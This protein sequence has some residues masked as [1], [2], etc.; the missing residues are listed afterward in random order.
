MNRKAIVIGA[1]FAGL[2]A[3]T[4]LAHK[5]WDVT[6]LEKNESPG[7]RGRLM[8]QEGYHFDMG[9][10]WYWMP[11]IFER[12]F[13]QFGKSA[14]D[15]YQLVRLNPSYRVFFGKDDLMD[16]PAEMEGLEA[17]FESREPGSRDKLREFL[18]QAAYKYK[19][20]IQE[21]V[22]KPSLSVT[23]FLQPR[24]LIDAIRL[25]I[26]ESLAKHARRFFSDP[27][28]LQLVEFPILFLGATPQNT[29]ALYSLMNYADMSLGTWYPMGGMHKIGEA[30]ASLA[31][32]KGVQ[33]VYNAQVTHLHVSK[34]LVQKVETL[35]G[36]FEADVVIAGADY[37]H[38]ET[39]LLQEPYRSYSPAYWQSRTMAPS[40][41]IFYLGIDKKLSNL[42]HHNLF[43]DADFNA[44]AQ[45]I[46]TTP[47]WPSDPLFYTS[48]T[49]KTDPGV[50]PEGHENMFILMPAA[51]DLEDNEHVRQQY[52]HL[53][54]KRLENLT[55]QPIAPH[56]VYQK[57]FAHKEFK[58][59]YHSFRGNAYGL[60]NTLSQ[61]A[62][63]KS[64]LKSRK[65][66]NLY[67][68]GQL[69]VPGPGVPPSLISGEVV[70]HQVIK[71]YD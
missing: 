10:S 34:S 56:I 44:H 69:T 36:D 59:E 61:T 1:G 43:F 67:Y 37:H 25:Q 7:G 55:G 26:F 47:R 39:S 5:G 4:H 40:S 53:L 46:Y 52:Y 27:R 12:Y 18:A 20:G 17:L 45:E 63:L 33:L 9:P 64:R 71:S 11:D 3:A 13:N 14:A 21:F 16:L 28:L 32:E 30:M 31:A 29:P 49:S 24:Y 2:S 54:I 57:S 65:V 68:T 35:K 62:I 70:A 60:A 48:L 42:L 38:V 22:Y 41:L 51:P 50:A 15:Y 8:S 6:I 23:E 58:S 19:V 66:K